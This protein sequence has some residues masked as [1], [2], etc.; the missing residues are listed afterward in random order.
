MNISNVWKIPRW[1]LPT[2]GKKRPKS[3]NVWKNV[4]QKFQRLEN[5]TKI[6]P[7]LGMSMA[8]LLLAAQA[9][10]TVDAAL[11]TTQADIEDARAALAAQRETIAAER[12]EL[13]ATYEALQA[14]V[15]ALREE[16]RHVQRVKSRQAA[17]QAAAQRQAE[18]TD[19]EH[20]R[21]LAVL[22]EYRRA[23]ESAMAAVQRQRYADLLQQFD[24]ALSAD[25][26]SGVTLTAVDPALALARATTETDLPSVPFEGAV[27]DAEGRVRRGTLVPVGP[28]TFFKGA[29]GTTGYLATGAG[30][31][32]PLLIEAMPHRVQQALDAWAAGD[33]VYAPVDVT[34]GALLKVAQAREPF[35]A[36]LQQ[37]GVVMIPL[38]LIG[39]GCVLIIVRRAWVLQRM[40]IDVNAPLDRI[41][42]AL[43]D[44]D[45]EAARAVVDTLDAPWRPVLADA[46]AH[47]DAD[48]VYLE[49][50]LMDRIVMQ[51]PLVTKYLGALAICAA[52]APLLGLLGTVTGMINTF[53][54]ITVFGTGDA[55]SL[56]GGIS[57]ALITTQ[58]GLIIAVPVLLAHAYLMR[59]A[60]NVLSGL[61]QAAIR[62][63]RTLDPESSP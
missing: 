35:V 56:S 13:S 4:P 34:D 45:A 1:P 14:E 55:R 37:G 49:E 48:R 21:T 27:V 43:R 44:D 11:T 50:I 9:S 31:L 58:T 7:M 16:W 63:V 8:I 47:R 59:R 57:E 60:R 30:G 6:L 62:F 20:R 42:Q 51:R 61:E 39:V 40:E 23:S 28:V 19:A 36:R 12:T 22:T 26:S 33:T 29:D 25:E 10:A 52:A 54:L 32:T 18:R 17:E 46:V 3:S 24:E 15:R 41:T 53:Q 38:L 2:F 5:R